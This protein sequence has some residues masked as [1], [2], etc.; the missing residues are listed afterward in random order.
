MRKILLIYPKYKSF[1]IRWQPLKKF[2]VNNKK[3]Y[4]KIMKKFLFLMESERFSGSC[5]GTFTFAQSKVISWGMFHP[6]KHH[7][8]YVKYVFRLYALIPM[9][10]FTYSD[11][12]KQYLINIGVNEKKILELVPQFLILIRMSVKI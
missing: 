1:K 11:C 3:S 2:H 4:P 10:I 9:K 8:V 12:G 7:G 6:V 5:N